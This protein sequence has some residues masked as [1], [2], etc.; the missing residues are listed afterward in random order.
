MSAIAATVAV[1]AVRMDLNMGLPPESC[2]EWSLLSRNFRLTGVNNVATCGVLTL[3][4]E[5]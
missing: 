1:T 5:S 4:T 3:V 2:L